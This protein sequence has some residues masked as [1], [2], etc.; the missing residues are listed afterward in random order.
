MQKS[1]YLVVICSSCLSL[2]ATPPAA[3]AQLPATGVAPQAPVASA[4]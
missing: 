1:S 2:F 4:H 3:R